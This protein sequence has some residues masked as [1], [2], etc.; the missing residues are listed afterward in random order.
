MRF[1]EMLHCRC[2][3]WIYEAVAGVFNISTGK[4][5]NSPGVLRSKFVHCCCTK[6]QATAG[7]PVAV[8]F[9]SYDDD[10]SM[11]IVCACSAAAT[12]YE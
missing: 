11:V 1:L 2:C 8:F 3:L 12:S 6:I 5:G 4:H 7:K 10:R 9:V